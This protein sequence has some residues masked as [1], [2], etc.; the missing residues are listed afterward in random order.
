[1]TIA[2]AAGDLDVARA[3]LAELDEAAAQCDTTAIVASASAAGGALALAEGRPSE[4]IVALREGWRLWCD[5]GARFDAAQIRTLLGQAYALSGDRSAARLEL[6]GARAAFAELGALLE[7]QQVQRLL[8]GMAPGVREIQ[9]FM[10]TDI[11]DSTRLVELLGD[12]GWDSLLSWHDR[13]VREALAAHQG[14]EIKHEGDGFSSCLP[15][16]DQH[17]T[18]QSPCNGPSTS[19]GANTASRHGFASVYTRPR[20]RC[21]EGTSSGKASTWQPAS[22][23]QAAPGRSSLPHRRWRQSARA[24][25]HLSR[26]R[27]P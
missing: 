9:T 3:A 24:T 19:I 11:V 2:V 1:V 16:H 8:A 22:R 12:D 10:F 6:E 7:E 21:G 25:R 20:R 26:N 13:I 14:R 27:S 5:L 23:P 4:A 18:A 15:T 17:W